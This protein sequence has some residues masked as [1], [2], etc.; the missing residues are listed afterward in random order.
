MSKKQLNYPPIP[1]SLIECLCRDFPDKLP[2][3]ELSSF[4]LGIKLGE[5]RVIDKIKFEKSEMEVKDV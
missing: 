4:Q 2:R 1:D 5:Q 3:E